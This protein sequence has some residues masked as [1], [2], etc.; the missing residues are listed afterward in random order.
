M[1]ILIFLYIRIKDILFFDESLSFTTENILF[2]ILFRFTPGFSHSFHHLHTDIQ[3]KLKQENG[4]NSSD[5]P[6]PDEENLVDVIHSLHQLF[7]KLCISDTGS[8]GDPKVNTK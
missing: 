2:Y 4:R 8:N 5:K 1:Q 3:A 6:D 7:H